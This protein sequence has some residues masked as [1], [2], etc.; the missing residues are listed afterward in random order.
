ML[1]QHL[2]QES[3]FRRAREA[4]K[5]LGVD[6]VKI[7]ETFGAPP[8]IA[9]ESAAAEQPASMTWL[10]AVGRASTLTRDTYTLG[11]LIDVDLLF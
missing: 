4:A 2:L 5:V 1:Q 7:A 3:Q 10:N 8:R 11:P 6:E 9:A